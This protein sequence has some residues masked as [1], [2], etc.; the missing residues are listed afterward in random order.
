MVEFR[1]APSRFQRADFKACL[2]VFGPFREKLLPKQLG[3]HSVGYGEHE[4]E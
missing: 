3:I 2:I 4:A 1:A